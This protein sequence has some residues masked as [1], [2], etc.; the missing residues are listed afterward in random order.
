MRGKLTISLNAIRNNYQLLNQKTDQAVCSAVIK[1]D[2][3]GLGMKPVAENLHD[4]GITNFFVAL[5]EEGIELR[6]IL[7][8]ATIYVLNGILPNEEKLFL[9]HNLVPVL[10]DKSQTELWQNG[11]LCA[12]HV[13]TGLN[14]LGFNLNDFQKFDLNV[15]L[16]MSHLACADTPDSWI[17]KL[18]L[19]R[20]TEA[21][22]KYPDAK[23][24]LAAS[25]GIFCGPDYYFDMVRPGAA[26]YGLN[27]TPSQQNPMQQVVQLSVPVL[28]TRIV[29]QDGFVGY[30]ATKEV[31]KGQRLATV[32]LGY[33]DGFFRSLSNAG[34][35]YYKDIAL[36]VLGRVSMDVITVD[37]SALPENALNAGDWLDVFGP[38]Q[39]P[40]QLAKAA[41]TI[42]YELLTALGQRFERVYT[43]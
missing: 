13:D 15:Q 28:Q 22:Q 12:L 32:S 11:K 36:P 38:N 30:A 31:K 25:D 21:S 9:E 5:L 43:P 10:N 4:T 42:G 33:A 39:S 41:G 8:E 16:V 35:L 37:I 17:N 40:D 3:Y 23:K 7:P 14:R 27:P 1:A 20:F 18:Q 6:Q 26:L 24:S 19:Q 2:A 29:E 34:R